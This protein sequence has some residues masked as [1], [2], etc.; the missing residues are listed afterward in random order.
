M[1]LSFMPKDKIQSYSIKTQ[2]HVLSCF[3]KSKL[4]L[5]NNALTVRS[6]K[7]LTYEN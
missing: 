3:M 2:T 7:S 5:I 4:S 6:L 1:I